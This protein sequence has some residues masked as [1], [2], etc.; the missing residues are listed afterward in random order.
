MARDL[1]KLAASY[2]A[3]KADMGQRSAIRQSLHFGRSYSF[4]VARVMRFAFV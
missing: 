4:P 3:R 1:A 2:E